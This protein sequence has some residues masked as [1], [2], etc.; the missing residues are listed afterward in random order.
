MATNEITIKKT[1]T[2]ALHIV[3]GF[4]LI[5]IMTTLFVIAILASVAYP[6]Y[7]NQVLKSKRSEGKALLLEVMQ[8]QER[9]K[10]ENGSYTVDLT[11]LG[12]PATGMLSEH[13]YYTVVVSAATATCPITDCIILTGNASGS[14]KNHGSLRLRS[15]GDKNWKKNDASWQQGWPDS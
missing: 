9:F 15:D 1:K 11:Q 8:L 12:L 7:Q 6:S 2:A 4:T 3:K 13:K 10:T 5:E 14:N